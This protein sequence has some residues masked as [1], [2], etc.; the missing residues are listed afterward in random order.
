M[1]SVQMYRCTHTYMCIYIYVYAQTFMC[2]YIY[3]HRTKPPEEVISTKVDARLWK[4]SFW[5]EN[6]LGPT[7]LWLA[8]PC[9]TDRGRPEFSR[10]FRRTIGLVSRSY[11]Y[12][13]TYESTTCVSCMY[14]CMYV[15]TYVCMYSCMVMYVC[16]VFNALYVCIHVCIHVC[17]HV[18]M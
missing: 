13:Y 14:V 2:V 16:N 15:C 17:M 10:A 1:D 18:L 6:R 3:E 8:D 12:I 5:Y 7:Y 4:S 11:I 9:I